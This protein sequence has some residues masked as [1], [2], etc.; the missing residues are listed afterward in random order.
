MTFNVTLTEKQVKI[1]QQE[2]D[3]R[4]SQLQNILTDWVKDNYHQNE[5][6]ALAEEAELCLT[7]RARMAKALRESGKEGE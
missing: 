5:W 1:I 7:V 4:R 3:S 6:K 2:M